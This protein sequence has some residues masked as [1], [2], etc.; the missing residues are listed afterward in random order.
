M[1]DMPKLVL[2]TGTSFEEWGQELVS[3]SSSP[4]WATV[5][6]EDGTVVGISKGTRDQASSDSE[7][8]RENVNDSNTDTD[9]RNYISC[10]D[11]DECL[12]DLLPR[13][14]GRGYALPVDWTKAVAGWRLTWKGSMTVTRMCGDMTLRVLEQSENMLFWKTTTHLR[15]EKWLSGLINCS[16]LPKPLAQKFTLGSQRPQPMAGQRLWYCHL[17]NTIPTIIY[18]YEKGTTRV[19]VG[20]QGLHTSNALCC[21]NVSTS[22]GLKSFC[23]WC[24]KP[25]GN[26]ETI[27]THLWEV[28]YWLTIICNGCKAFASMSVQIILEHCLGCKVKSQKEVQGKRAGESL[29]VS[30]NG[31]YKSCWAE[32]HPR[33][34]VE[35]HWWMW[36][37]L[38]VLTL[39]SEWVSTQPYKL[40]CLGFK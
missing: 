25:G 22:V 3:P 21:S 20:L 6:P 36:V 13:S 16:T 9:S 17:N 7:S 29:L 33:P 32:R 35:F 27:A 38:V 5:N 28:H 31:T 39:Y 11:T 4:A 34:S 8:S 2:G 23:P 1:E 18:F 14:T 19:M 15:C 24:F 30:L 37:A 26:M 40:S 10:S 12:Y